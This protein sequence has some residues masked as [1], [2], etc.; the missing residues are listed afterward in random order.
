MNSGSLQALFTAECSHTFHFQC[1]TSNVAHGNLVCPLCKAQ[2]KQLPFGAPQYP[3]PPQPWGFGG[4][5]QS[6]IPSQASFLSVREPQ[7][8]NDD[9]QLHPPPQMYLVDMPR[10]IPNPATGTME[11]KTF[12]EYPAV[13]KS[14]SKD[15]FAI[16][17]HLK[18]PGI[19]SGMPESARAPLDLVTVLDVSGSMSG[20]KMNLLK[21]AMS[22]VIQNLGPADRLSIISF[23]S[24]ARR[25]I[26]LTRM[27]NE[28]V[29]LALNA[30]DSLIAG[31]MTNIAEGL[32]KGA[33]VLEESQYKNPVNGIIL[34]SDGQD[35]YTV[36]SKSSQNS[37]PNYDCLLPPSIL[38]P[39]GR[40][41]PIH[42]FGFGSD[43]DSLAMHRIAEASGGTFSF[44]EDSSGIQDAFAQCIG[45][46]LSVVAQETH[47][48]LESA[49]CGVKI[50][51][52]KSGSYESLVENGG[53][54][55]LINV[56]DLYADE[57]R[58]FL[59]FVNVPRSGIEGTTK[60]IKVNTVI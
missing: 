45:G 11:L 32:R 15:D 24:A 14:L 21:Q 44:I 27:S 55:G 25:L 29:Q 26:R 35:N 58:S 31:G 7:V 40:P 12:T 39:A 52:I 3:I 30:V 16:L 28:G 18:A 56:D 50:S 23:S 9:D 49:N 13:A 2:W 53:L 48:T 34:L 42:T 36:F 17:I 57:E 59:L 10:H 54:N 60:L 37:V 22:F 20:A 6:Q 43:H 1:I 41:I 33:K 8:F 46:L 5:F 47:I 38:H 4:I 51:G 19:A